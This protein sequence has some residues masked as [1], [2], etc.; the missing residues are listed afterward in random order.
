MD[1]DTCPP[2]WPNWLWWWIHHHPHGKL[3][4]DGEPEYL[5]EIREPI[6]ALLLALQ[7]YVGL[8]PLAGRADGH[9]LAPMRQQA[10]SEMHSAIQQ[11]TAKAHV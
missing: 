1:I 8:E 3:P 2:W 6:E 7:T 10:V 9:L 5:K 4:G 11:L